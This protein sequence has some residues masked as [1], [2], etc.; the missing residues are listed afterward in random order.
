[1]IFNILI[2]YSFI[3]KFTKTQI[4]RIITIFLYTTYITFYIR[5]TFFK[6]NWII[7]IFI[8][9]FIP[10]LIGNCHRF[11]EYVRFRFRFILF[12]RWLRIKIYRLLGRLLKLNL[13]ITI[14]LSLSVQFKILK[15]LYMVW[16]R[17]TFF[18]ILIHSAGM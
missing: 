14:Y 6:Y 13:G 17:N 15:C 10:L 12:R 3:L 9:L 2:Y 5:F 4:W 1:M 7:I 18:R 8:T 16:K 11:I